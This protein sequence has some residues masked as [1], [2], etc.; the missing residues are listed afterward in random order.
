MQLIRGKKLKRIFHDHWP[1]FDR[2]HPG[3]R[4]AIRKNVDKMLKCGTEDAGFHHYK[5]LSCGQERKVPHT[6]KSRFCPSCGVGQTERWIEQYTILFANTIYRHIIF[7]PP[8]EF[9]PFFGL[10]REPY[11]N[12]LYTTVNQ[13]LKDWYQRK[14][15]IPGIMAVMHTFGRDEKFTPHIHALM[16][17][18]GID[19]TLTSWVACDYLPYPFFKKHFRDHFLE[20]I[21]KLW[22]QQQ[23]DTIPEKLRFLFTWEY[24][25]KIIHRLLSITWYVYIGEKLSNA[26]FTVR[27]IGRYT[28]RPAIAESR[29]IGYD[30]ETVTFN[31]VDHKTDKLT[32]HTLPSEEF[33]GKLIR[34][35]PDENF[36]IIRY[37]GFYANRV[38]GTLL[39][40]AFA[41]LQQ[42]YEKAIQKLAH[43]G[44]WWR[45][46]IERFT[47][48]D[49]LICSACLVP[50]A[51]I[52]VV[53]VKR[54]ADPYG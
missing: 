40:K 43:L 35:I 49:P 42:D 31:F 18:G 33:I 15:F 44:S 10:D 38:R 51:F 54:S 29:I 21:Q 28:K 46:Q 25:Q 27:Y 20:N 47:K 34:H 23:L 14:G 52:S 22:I 6:C 50:L 41:I 7:H 45:K 53:Y 19:K 16:T 26:Q 1:E 12:M 5:C 39:P 37:G 11:F 30:G 24:Q 9:R 8:S 4:P 2:D 3:I 36:R 13:T 32:Y 48:L 17:S